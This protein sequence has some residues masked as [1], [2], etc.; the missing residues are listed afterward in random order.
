[1]KGLFWFKLKRRLRLVFVYILAIVI[2]A[3]T[4]YLIA[5]YTDAFRSH[6]PQ[7]YEPKDFERDDWLRQKRV[8]NV[9]YLWICRK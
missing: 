3:L 9:W 7:Y 4:G 2:I 5:Q 1:M 6:S 8:E